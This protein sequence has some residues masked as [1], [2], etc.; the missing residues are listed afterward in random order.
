MDNGVGLSEVLA[1]QAQLEQALMTTSVKGLSL[2]PAG[3]LPP[4][5]A[6]LVGSLKMRQM[7]A[8]FSEAYDFIVVDSAPAML[9][10]DA[11]PLSAMADGTL[12]VINSRETP[13]QAAIQ[14]CARLKYVGAKILGVVLNRVDVHGS[15]F[16]YSNYYFKRY[17]NSYYKNG[18][19][20]DAQA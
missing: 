11:I 5:P 15:D 3:A 12:M 8:Q 2:L 18:N 13:R 4:D 14:A 9:V 6:E 17:E 10:S 1:G 20:H 19:G 7:L 16:F